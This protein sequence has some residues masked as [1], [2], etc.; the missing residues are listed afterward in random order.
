VG[1]PRDPTAEEGVALDLEAVLR[2]HAFMRIER[3]P[4][5]WQ[6]ETEDE[7]FLK[8]LG[9]MIVVGLGRGNE[10]A[11]LTLN[12]SNVRV[13]PDTVETDGIPVGDYVALSIRGGGDWG[14][15]EI[16]RAGQG[17]TT[18]LL[19][20]VAPAAAAAG[21][22]FAYTRNLGHGAGSVTALVPRVD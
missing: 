14:A 12:V 2:A 16:W 15:D 21:A 19:A 22:V 8:M 18:G 7:P 3:P 10:L 1:V 6:P 5:L 9:E 11:R 17:P 13:E 20:N 4:K